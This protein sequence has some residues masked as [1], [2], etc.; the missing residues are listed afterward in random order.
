MQK[1][2][3]L[4]VNPASGK[5]QAKNALF[6]IVSLFNENGY[7]V[8]VFISRK[9]HDP[10]EFARLHSSQYD[11]VVCV[12]GD[13]TFSDVVNG[14]MRTPLPP[15]VGY[16][17]M[18]T[19]NDLAASL[20]IPRKPLEAGQGDYERAARFP[21]MW[22]ALAT[23]IL[24]IFPPSARLPRFS[25]LT[26]QESKRSLGHLAYV[27]EGL[28]SLTQITP[29]HTVVEHDSGTIEG[30]FVFGGVTN[31]T[32]V[33]GLVKLDAKDVGFR[34][35]LFEVILVKNPMKISDLND[36][37]THILT[38]NFHSNQVCLLHTQNVRFKF[39]NKVPWT[40]DGEDGGR[41]REI[42]IK[43]YKEAIQIVL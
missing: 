6:G 24:R 36:I 33:A 2:L 21:W 34:D 29:R 8:T 9:K 20:C 12:G 42:E 39:L 38:K 26:P 3:M 27:L 30:S 25:Y 17:P 31:S 22:A 4:I 43:N 13:G 41:H 7:T 1:R 16:I 32:S 37:V 10:G 19:A 23:D 28:S 35:G 18:G 11:L 15:P 14:L 40:L 5:G